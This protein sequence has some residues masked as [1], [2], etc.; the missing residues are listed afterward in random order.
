MLTEHRVD[1]L[2]MEALQRRAV[3]GGSYLVR[4]SPAQTGRWVTSQPHVA[5]EQ[6]AGA[7]EDLTA[8]EID[9]LSTSTDSPFGRITYLAPIAQLSETPARW[10]RSAVPLDHDEAAWLE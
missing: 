1:E 8:E 7:A 2:L 4:I 5:P 10:E 3:E 6:V 9:A